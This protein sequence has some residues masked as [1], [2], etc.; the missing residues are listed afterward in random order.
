MR[1]ILQLIREKKNFPQLSWLNPGQTFLE[2]T[3]KICQ[4]FVQAWENWHLVASKV[5]DLVY[6][7]LEANCPL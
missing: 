3:R 5:Y 2:C 4:K 7:K 1:E 6:G